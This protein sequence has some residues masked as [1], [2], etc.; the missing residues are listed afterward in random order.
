VGKTAIIGLDGATFRVLDPL[1]AAGVMP[2]LGALRDRGAHGVLTSTTPAYTPPAWVSMLT[3]VNPGRHNVYGFLAS[4]PQEPAAIAHAG[5]IAATPIW[6]HAAARGASIGVYHVP[7]TYP[8]ATDVGGFLVAGGLAAGWTS[9]DV[10]GFASDAE[11]AG[12]IRRVSGGDYPIDTVVSYD[13]DWDRPEAVREVTRIQSTRREVLAALLAQREVDMVFAVF[14]G[15]DR[16]QHLHYQY[17][18]ECS[19]WY[20]GPRASQ[21]RDLGLAYFAELD[22]A[23]A[24]LAAWAGSDGDVLIVSDHGAG[25]WEKTVN[26]NLLLADWGYLRLPA[27]SRVTRAGVVAGPIQ[28][29]ARRLVPRGLLLK[30]K[31]RINRGLDWSQVQAFA[32]QVA[33][34]GIHVNEAGALPHGVL[35]AA[36]TAAVAAEITERLRTFVDPDDGEPVVD[37]VVPRAEVIEGPFAPRA[38]HLFPICR[39]QRYELSDTLAATSPVTDHRDRPWGYHHQDGVFI[40]AGPSFVGGPLPSPLRIVDV[41]PTAFQVAGLS[42]PEGLDGRV[43]TEI[44]TD[45]GTGDLRAPADG[46][47]DAASAGPDAEPAVYPFSEEDERQI[48]ESLRG[49]GYLE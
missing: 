8:P 7:M 12:V 6:R 45:G 42:V 36:R 22:R 48:E 20:H 40:G 16:L 15:T 10:G 46:A 43:A 30:A 44:L 13:N 29:I 21:M 17:L 49:L 28:T 27:V 34:Q 33:E 23:I 35:D 19:D 25:P 11:V 3:G 39:D 2:A 5:T 32:S 38:P 47:D 31:S 26:V 9:P 41:L 24:D 4:S 37:R 14:E 18:V 1:V